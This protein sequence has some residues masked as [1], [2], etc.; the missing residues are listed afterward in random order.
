MI[1]LLYYQIVRCDV[2]MCVCNS[3]LNPFGV[4][5]DLREPI[6]EINTPAPNRLL[7]KF[8]KMW[9]RLLVSRWESF[10]TLLLRHPRKTICKMNTRTE[11]RAKTRKKVV[12]E[13]LKYVYVCMYYHQYRFI[14]VITLHN[15]K[16][17]NHRVY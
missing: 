9:Q 2:C 6:G 8:V 12:S 16:N 1:I 14:D 4:C 5:I 10:L 11:L 3:I 7:Q 13:S 15:N 17:W